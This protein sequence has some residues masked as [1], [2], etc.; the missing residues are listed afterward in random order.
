M[1]VKPITNKQVVASS[2]INR[3][4]QVSSKDTKVRGG[5][6]S[7]SVVPGNNYSENYAI[8][9]KDVD[10]AVM[11]HIKSVIRPKVREAN[12]TVDVTVMYGNEER[13]KS[14]RKRGTMRDKNGSIVLP[15]I[16]LKRTEVAKNELFNG[17]EHDVKREFA[18]VT[19]NSKW[20]KNNRYDR[21][22]V[23]TGTKPVTENILTSVPNFVDVS[24]EFVLWTNFIE[25]MN[26]LIETFIEHNRTYWGESVSHKFMCSLD[27]ISDASEMNQDGERFIKSTF[28]VN[29]KAYLLPEY[30]NS[31]ITNKISQTQRQLTPGKVVF[32]FE[33]DATNKQ[34]GK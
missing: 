21:F 10:T 23:Q 29:T 15:L 16:M 27:S 28:S 7:T 25:Q 26:P 32:G 20:S 22:S 2:K 33:G 9:L 14:V 18:E 19:R 8:T 5:N 31:V 34:V 3:A 1:A 12:E 13:W 30:T 4:D 11:S 17:F 24:Y 6:R